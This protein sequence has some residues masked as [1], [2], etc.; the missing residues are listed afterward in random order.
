MMPGHPAIAFFIIFVIFAISFFGAFE[1]LL[2]RQRVVVRPVVDP[3]VVGGR[4]D[5]DRDGACRER[6]EHVQAI[7]LV[8]RESGARGTNDGL[9]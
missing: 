2:T 7:G 4:R 8:E 6:A 5:D 9:R 3:E 1:I